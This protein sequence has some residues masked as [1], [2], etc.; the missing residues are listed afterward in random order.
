VEI[1]VP[2][3]AEP[4]APM[5]DTPPVPAGAAPTSELQAFRAAKAAPPVVEPP[6]PEPVAAAP[7]AEPVIPAEH[8]VVDDDGEQYDKRTRAGK[9]V[10]RLLGENK[11]LKA[12]ID[13]LSRP[14]PQAAAP[15]AAPAPV[16]DK[17]PDA[18]DLTKYP[19]GEY[20]P[21]YLS[22]LARHAARQEH[23]TLEAKRADA[24]RAQQQ[25]TDRKAKQ[26][27][28]DKKLPEVKQRYPDFDQAYDALYAALAGTGG[29]HR[30]LVTRLLDSEIGHDTAH[31]LGTH[32]EAVQALFDAKTFDA[33]VRA[34]GELEAQV[35]ASLKPA[36]K[37]APPVPVPPA[38][39]PPVGASASVTTYDPAT[40]N[41]QQFRQKHGV[42]GGQR[43]RA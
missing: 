3:P 38:P 1:P 29:R 5:V 15:V 42:I 36:P 19:A 21:R 16:E 2:A 41:L 11:S 26:D 31:Y 35:K 32:P 6:K 18:A 7:A 22:D 13:E 10:M 37:P 28:W 4:I 27:G 25:E 23:Q 9:R 39:I 43:I 14:A 8:V 33:H 20:D 17:E 34:I 40:A 24:E 30:Y 12:R